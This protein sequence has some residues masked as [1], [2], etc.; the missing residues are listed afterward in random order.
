MQK[1]HNKKNDIEKDLSVEK[2]VSKKIVNLK[3]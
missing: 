2:Y 3:K 1:R